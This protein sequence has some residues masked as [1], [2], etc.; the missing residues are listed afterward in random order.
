MRGTYG[1]VVVSDIERCDTGVC[2][3]FMVGLHVY[4]M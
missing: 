1:T 4:W 2:G 3:A